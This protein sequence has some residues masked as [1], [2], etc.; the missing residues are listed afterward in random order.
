ML[1]EFF[2]S[3]GYHVLI[4]GHGQE[5][6]DLLDQKSTPRPGLI[7]TDFSMPVMNGPEFLLE[8]ERKHP[9]IFAQ[10]PIFVMSAGSDTRKLAVK[11]TGFVKK[12]FDLNE[13]SIISAKYRL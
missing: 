9:K 12:P 4:A 1:E 11:I 8:L 10:T 3:E 6:L 7:L 13:L 5:A 2:L